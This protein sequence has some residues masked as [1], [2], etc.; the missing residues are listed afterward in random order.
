M[1]DPS[2]TPHVLDLVAAGARPSHAAA[3][4]QRSA[5]APSRS[6]PRVT[7]SSSRRSSTC[8]C[9]RPTT[10]SCS[11]TAGCARDADAVY[12]AVRDRFDVPLHTVI[13]TH[14]HPRPLL[15][16]HSLPRRGERPAGPRTRTS[17]GASRRTCAPRGSTRSSTSGNGSCRRCRGRRGAAMIS[18]GP[19]SPTAWTSSS[20]ASAARCS[21][22]P[23]RHGRDR[24]PHVGL[25]LRA[26]H[27]RVRGLLLPDDA[28]LRQP[29]QGA[30]LPRG[31]GGRLRGDGRAGAELTLPGHGEPIHG[32]E[33]IRTGLLE[34]AEFLHAVVDQTLEGLNPGLASR[35]DR[36]V[37][38]CARASRRSRASAADL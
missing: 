37:D 34:Q 1:A 14:G 18:S 29:E 11:S 3:A 15:R 8:T 26:P 13:F 6:A 10:V 28:Q 12:G 36:P 30:A 35:R 16:S 5:A 19:T 33:Q 32:A 17:S 25:H 9:S 23:A 38:P 24:R 22:L 20:C 4:M 27:A 21:R 2:D 7:T 31:M